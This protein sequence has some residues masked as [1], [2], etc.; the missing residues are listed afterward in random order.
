MKYDD[1]LKSF[2][3]RP[4]FETADLLTLFPED[5]AQILPRLSRWVGAGKLVRLRRGKYMLP[6]HYQALAVHPF[7]ISNYLYSPSYISLYTALEYYKLIPEHTH[8]I[9]AV[10][11]RDT[12]RWQTPLGSFHYHSLK[13]N[14]FL[15]YKLIKMGNHSQQN[16]L[17]AS[18]EKAL[19]DICLLNSGEWDF[20]RWSSLRLQNT[21]VLDPDDLFEYTRAIPSRKL[22]RGMAALIQYLMETK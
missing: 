5:E 17:I 8:P 3:N 20:V 9:Q 2:S 10:T 11:T 21:E 19:V 16:A 1:L 12:R 4:F 6:P 13:T 18:P 7:Y 22:A 14:R 15:G